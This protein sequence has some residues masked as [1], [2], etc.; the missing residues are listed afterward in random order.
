M[1]RGMHFS[2]LVWTTIKSVSA[3]FFYIN[4]RKFVNR[5]LVK[6]KF[7]KYVISNELIT[8]KLPPWE[9]DKADTSSVCPSSE[10]SE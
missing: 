5:K 10:R 9:D 4:K 6:R 8:V 2:E 1:L 7:V 3:I